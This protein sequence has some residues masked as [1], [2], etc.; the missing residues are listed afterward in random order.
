[1]GGLRRLSGPPLAAFAIQVAARLSGAFGFD[2]HW[3]GF[4]FVMACRFR[5][6][7]ACRFGLAAS[8]RTSL[9]VAN[10][11]IRPAGLSPAW[12]P[13]SP[14]HTRTPKLRWRSSL[15]QPLIALILLIFGKF[16]LSPFDGESQFHKVFIISLICEISGSNI[17]FGVEAC[18]RIQERPCRHRCG[19]FPDSSAAAHWAKEEE[20]PTRF[21][22][23]YRLA[24]PLRLA[25]SSPGAVANG[26][27]TWAGVIFGLPVKDILGSKIVTRMTVRYQ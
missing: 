4:T 8:S 16:L 18:G 2:A 14:A 9:S 27:R 21:H 10:R 13:A 11:L 17:G 26:P 23:P 15:N 7:P 24:Q 25:A 20:A 19:P 22:F 1:M 12:L 6:C 3:M 5:R